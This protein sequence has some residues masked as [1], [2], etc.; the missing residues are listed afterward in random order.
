MHP[1]LVYGEWI[2]LPTYFTCLMVGFAVAG[3]V[4]AREAKREG[5]APQGILDLAM[6]TLPAALIGAR[7]AH[8]VLV[9]PRYYLAEPWEVLQI[10]YGGFVFYGGLGSAAL[11]LFAWARR[12]GTSAW[13]LGD[14][15]A[16]ATCF[17]LMFGRLGCLGAGCCYGKPADWPL[18]VEVPWSVQYWRRGH[19]PDEL[20]AMP[21]HPSP[22]YEVLLAWSLFVGLSFWRARQRVP[23]EVMLG[24]VALY[25]VGRSVL[26]VFRADG[27]RGLYL[28]GLLSTSQIIGLVS[29]GLAVSVLLWRRRQ[30]ALA[31]LGAGG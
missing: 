26:E 13:R 5:L 22:L 4:L 29:A 6:L 18:G 11:M 24:F 15:F 17:G 8:V 3:V 19:V 25:G 2:R 1:W 20:L 10:T 16:P 28:H 21:L 7:L 9:A 27:S 14:I 30:A 23:G 31:T 12:T